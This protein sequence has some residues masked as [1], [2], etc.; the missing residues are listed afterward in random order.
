MEQPRPNTQ[1]DTNKDTNKDDNESLKRCH[2]CNKKL[3]LYIF[4][5]RCEN[6]Y[7]LKC[8][9]SIVHGCHFDY[10]GEQMKRIKESNPIIRPE[11]IIKI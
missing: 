2:Q 6:I 3:S 1:S 9:D 7:C 11:K 10:R 8:K 4:N 5:C